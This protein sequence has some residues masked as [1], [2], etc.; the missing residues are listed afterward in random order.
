MLVGLSDGSLRLYYDPVNSVRGALLCVSRPLRRARQQ[1]VIREEL[2]L[3]RK[4]PLF[5]GC[6]AFQND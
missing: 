6:I 1:E 5:Y 3:S 4:L 2:V